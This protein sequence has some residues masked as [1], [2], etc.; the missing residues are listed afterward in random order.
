MVVYQ[1]TI[2][3]V[4]GFLSIVF[5]FCAAY[6]GYRIYM[7][8]R[9][10]KWWLALVFAFLIQ[11]IRRVITLLSDLGTISPLEG[12]LAFADRVIMFVI[13][14]LIVVGLWE[15]MHSFESFSLVESKVS[16]KLR[17]FAKKRR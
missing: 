9:M 15:M 2:E 5:Q 7:F 17:S 13:S 3:L 10:S 1:S 12:N 14:A 11:G 6:F 8:N 16:D 4:L